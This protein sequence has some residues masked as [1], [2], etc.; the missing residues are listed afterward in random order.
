MFRRKF[1][2]RQSYRENTIH[3]DI[4]HCNS[5]VEFHKKTFM[6]AL[7]DLRKNFYSEGSLTSNILKFLYIIKKIRKISAKIN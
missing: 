4:L 7:F 3:V 1:K 2:R 6:V 5:T